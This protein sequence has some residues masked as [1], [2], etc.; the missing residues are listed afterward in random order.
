MP[1]VIKKS[2]NFASFFSAEATLNL[3]KKQ[4][5]KHAG[6]LADAAIISIGRDSLEDTSIAVQQA[7]TSCGG[8]LG[9]LRVQNC[10]RGCRGPIELDEHS[11]PTF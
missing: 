9:R 10:V 5:C 2:C 7:A 3:L 4:G 11:F 6:D 1:G 8:V